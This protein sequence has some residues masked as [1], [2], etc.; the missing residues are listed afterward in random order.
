MQGRY[1]KNSVVVQKTVAEFSTE[2][3]VSVVYKH[4]NSRTNCGTLHEHVRPLLQHVVSY[5]SKQPLHSPRRV[6]VRQRHAVIFNTTNQQLRPSTELQRQTARHVDDVYGNVL[7]AENQKTGDQQ[8]VLPTA[9][10]T[11]VWNTVKTITFWSQDQGT[12]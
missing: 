11:I 12:K 7:Q 5:P 1:E 10:E 8:M 6:W 3:P 2:F 9:A 4:K